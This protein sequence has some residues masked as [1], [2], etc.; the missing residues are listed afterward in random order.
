MKRLLY[1][2]AFLLSLLLTTTCFA[3]ER[4]GVFSLSPFV[5][6]YTFDGV[7]HLKTAPVYGLRLGYDITNN[8]GVEYVVDYLST[9]GTRAKTSINALSYRMDVLYNFMPEGRLVPYFALGGGGITAGHGSGFNAGGS[10]T[11]ASLNAGGGLKYFLT[12]SLALR[13]DA[14][15]LVL[16]ENKPLYNWEY[17]AGL[18]FLFGD[19]K[20]APAPVAPACNLAASPT[21]I[22]QGQSA[23]LNWTSQ[24]ATECNIQPNI[25]PVEPQGNRTVS[26]AAG[27]LYT[28]TCTGEGGKA[29]SDLTISVASVPKPLAPTCD[30]SVSPA[31]IMQGE[32]AKLNWTSQNATECDIQPGIGPVKPQGAADIN[33]SADTTYNLVC[34]GAGGK[35]NS[36]ASIM[37]AA[38]PAPTMEELCMTLH[39]E[40]DTDKSIIKPAYYGE[41]EKVANFMKRFP[42]IKGTIEGHTD[43]I[44]TA[45]YNVKLS[46]RRAAGVVKMLV[47]KYGID[48]SRLKAMGYGLTKPIASNKTVEDRQKNRRTMANFGCVSVEKKR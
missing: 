25:G 10:N 35:A 46:Q 14:R 9:D 18:T 45:E 34:N 17:T 28:L 3:G 6:G 11:D 48:K 32:S 26:P 2:T 41:V 15:Q 44:A 8:L 42:Q 13:G 22:M 29:S 38:P 12:D 19:K 27:T 39:I 23:K 5:G 33:P 37:V 20:P 40:Y 30:L 43:N 1:C 31:S 16:F 36:S 7:Q 4:E 24:N 21:S 47:E